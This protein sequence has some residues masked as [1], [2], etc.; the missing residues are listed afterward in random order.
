MPGDRTMERARP[1]V[2]PG[3]AI[4]FAGLYLV[5]ALTS[6]EAIGAGFDSIARPAGGVA[7]LWL[8][9]RQPGV[10]GIDT[11]L[12]AGV[13]FVANLLM[14][15]DL[16]VA[17]LVT[18]TNVLQTLLAVVPAATLVPHAVGVRWRAAAGPTAGAGPVLR[19]AGPCAGRG[20]HRADRRHDRD[21]GWCGLTTFEGTLWFGRNLC[22]ALVVRHVSACCWV[23]G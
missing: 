3:A 16:E 1:L 7:I 22:S 11:L 18:A 10:L 2:H 19:R 13:A 6:R 4:G 12:L 9:L 21:R 15:A 17:A 20:R 23:S 5:L 14:G 8:L